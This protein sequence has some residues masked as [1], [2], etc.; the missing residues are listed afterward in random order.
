LLRYGAVYLEVRY[1]LSI[2]GDRRTDG[3]GDV[4]EDGVPAAYA[5][6]DSMNA[7][8]NPMTESLKLEAKTE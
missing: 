4:I 1:D 2:R 6:I 3:K 8:V 5:L 7:E